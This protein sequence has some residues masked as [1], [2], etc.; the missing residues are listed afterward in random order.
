M[1]EVFQWGAFLLYCVIFLYAGYTS[2]LVKIS[3]DPNHNHLKHLL[4]SG[5]IAVMVQA[6]IYIALQLNWIVNCYGAGIGIAPD[7]MWLGYEILS[8]VFMLAVI[9]I[10]RI[11]MRG[12]CTLGRCK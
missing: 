6:G 12:N 7:S 5:L 2:Y 8:G 1:L 9:S 11:G 10:V 3:V 4:H